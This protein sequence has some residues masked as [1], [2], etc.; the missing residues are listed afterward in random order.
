MSHSSVSPSTSSSSTSFASSSFLWQSSSSSSRSRSR[1]SRRLLPMLLLSSCF[2][3]FSVTA[4]KQAIGPESVAFL[5]PRFAASSA[6]SPASSLTAPGPDDLLVYGAGYLGRLVGRHWLAEHPNSRVVAV[7]KSGESHEELRGLGFEPFLGSDL[8]RLSADQGAG[9]FQNVAVTVP[10]SGGVS[11]SGDDDYVNV[12]KQAL[13]W[14]SKAGSLVFTSSGGVFSEDGGSVVDESSP[15]SADS[16]PRSAVLLR[17]EQLIRSAGG[18]VLRLAGLYDLHRGAHQY[19][20][21][22]GIVR[23]NPEY[24]INLVHYEDA[25]KAVVAALELENPSPAGDL[26]LIGDGMP[27]SRKEIVEATSSNADFID[28]PKPQLDSSLP[29]KRNSNIGKR[30]D[31]SRARKFLQWA[32]TY[33]SF[34]SFMQSCR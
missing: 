18:V 29:S 1:R 14:R 2:A 13:R 30:Y 11:E 5:A 7:T 17:A 8:A 22:Q 10:P 26:F 6:A 23:G 25:A 33:S 12:L 19:W 34:A 4:W 24:K 16:S 20:W 21:N 31:V 28:R 27:L 15:T 32:P 9:K 3:A